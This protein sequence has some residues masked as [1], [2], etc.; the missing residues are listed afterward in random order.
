MAETVKCDLRSCRKT[1][2]L[3]VQS[4][5]PNDPAGT[6]DVCAPG[7]IA[8]VQRQAKADQKGGK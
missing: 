4:H 1:A 8:S 7:H 2:T 5:D 6:F 3:R